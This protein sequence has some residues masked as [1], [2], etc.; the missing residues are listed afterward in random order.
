MKIDPAR[1]RQLREQRA[2]SQ[3]Q[4]AEIAGINV[5]TLQ[6][7]ESGG[8]GS[9]DTRMALAAALQ[10]T[11]VELAEAVPAAQQDEAAAPAATSEAPQWAIFIV[12]LA[13]LFALMLIFGYQFGRDLAHRDRRAEER[14]A[15]EQAAKAHVSTAMPAADARQTPDK[16]PPEAPVSD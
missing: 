7:I 11:P 2:W 4:L 9:P 16:S 10:V 3:E 15:A 12:L 1:I 14:A 13:I 6:R 5:R 8:G